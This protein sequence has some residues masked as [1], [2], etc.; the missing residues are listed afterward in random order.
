VTQN[1][2]NSRSF[3]AKPQFGLQP[4]LAWQAILGFS[5]LS[6]LLL[7]AGVG[8][9]LNIAFPAGAFLVGILLYVR[10]P[11]LY[12]GFTW[13][14]WFLTPWVR[15]MVDF[16]SGY[17]DPS[18]I[19]LAPYLVTL[20]TVLTLLRYLPKS[21][22]IGGL[23]FLLSCIG[24]FYGLFIGLLQ[25]SPA[26]LITPFLK[27]STPIFLG[28]HLFANWSTYLVYRQV[29]RRVFLW[30]VL[31]TGAYGIF[32]FL[33]APEWD[34]FWLLSS[35]ATAFGTPEPLGI[36]VFSTMN[37]PGI[38]A[39][40]LMAGLL[41]LLSNQSPLQLPAAGFGYLAFMLSQV[42][43]SWLGWLVGLVTLF[44]AL[45]PRFQF[46]II[47]TLII[48]VLIIFLLAG[49]DQFSE[50]IH[51]RLQTFSSGQE[52][53]SYQARMDTYLLLIDLALSELFGKGLG[54]VIDIQG[55][56]SGDSGILSIFLLL[57]W[58]GAI[59]YVG[60]I[61]LALHCLFQNFQ[62]RSDPFLS[63]A[64]AISL[65]VV[66]QIPLGVATIDLSGVVFWSFTGLA[67]AGQKYYRVKELAD[68][69]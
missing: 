27:W 1:S 13:W 45:K 34:K 5:L 41:L 31:I 35:Q 51:S 44:P 16:R 37:G 30:G 57:G 25:S 28:F 23:P 63:A 24:V 54:Y 53:E 10:Y 62:G 8:R 12:L 40:V 22:R 15:R 48:V 14:L 46:R 50:V 67:M 42:R 38:F 39:V 11:I 9:I 49:L 33:V 29:I 7:A 58:L 60:G 4:A 69:E 43:S 21:Y 18:P 68:F 36:R 20:I 55:F 66:S 64:R 56:G 6:A 52:D 19:L 3:N 17:I 59:P 2:S 65:G 32:Q 47:V 61:I 26:S